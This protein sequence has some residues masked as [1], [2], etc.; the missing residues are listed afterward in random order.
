MK[1]QVIVNKLNRR[2]S[3]VTDFANKSNVVE[4]VNNGFTFESVA[5]IEN[6]LGVWH[7]DRDGMWA[8]EKG[9]AGASSASMLLDL[10]KQTFK[11]FDDLNIGQVWNKFSEKGNSVTIAVLD[12]GYNK[13]NSDIE[14]AVAKSSIIIDE[15]KY[16]PEQL[17]IDDKS[18]I[19]HGTRCASLIGARNELTSIIGIAPECKLL[20]GK[21]SINREIRKFE[22]LL[23]GIE[24]AINQG[25]DIIS[26]SYAVSLTDEE[27]ESHNA[28]F[29]S[30]VDNKPV[31]IFGA[32]GNSDGTPKKGER[33]PASFENCISIGSSDANHNVADFTVSSSKTILHAIGIDIESYGKTTIP[34]A[35]SGT[36]YSTPIAAAIAGLAISHIKK[37][38]EE[39]NKI[40]FVN[41]LIDTAD[42]I[43][44]E[45]NKK[46]INIQKLFESF[47]NNNT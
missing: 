31:L 18:N 9:L 19:G 39:I 4:V 30:L 47:E 35:Q 43:S 41:R 29:Q 13:G 21:I 44:G 8:W 23:N 34:D 25:A 12:T 17:I 14:Q 26:I 28:K 11:W 1:L 37:N 20:V 6:N 42:P 33:Y 5:R 45:Q 32:A 15:E 22:Y 46:I 40:D 16:D 27:V 38:G 2:K 3:P 24:W 7:Q 36:S 10:G